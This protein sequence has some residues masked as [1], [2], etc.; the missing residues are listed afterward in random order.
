M[1]KSFSK[2]YILKFSALI[3]I[4]FSI[5]SCTHS[6][7]DS[8]DYLYSINKF[9]L[10][11]SDAEGNKL[12]D[13]TSPSAI[14][15]NV[16]KQ[17]ETSTANII[18]YNSKKPLYN[19]KSNSSKINDNGKIMYLDGNVKLQNIEN[20]NIFIKSTKVEWHTQKSSINFLGDVFG[21]FNTT[22]IRSK[23]ATYNLNLER[24]TFYDI[25][26]FNII[27]DNSRKK[28]FKVY[29]SSAIWDGKSG[30]F[31]FFTNDQPVKSQVFIP[32]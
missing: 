11:Q 27:S 30:T 3:F 23:R 28:I 8:N 14:I 21:N 17:I 19:I 26:D 4:F 10:N 18:I 32:I 7:Q 1:L 20:K 25:Y 5:A 15:D 22:S 16:N 12:F 2:K 29:A 13:L 6:S 9:N 24:I 31:E